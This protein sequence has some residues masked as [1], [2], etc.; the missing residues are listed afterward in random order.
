MQK[1]LIVKTL[2]ELEIIIDDE[3]KDKFI[4]VMFEAYEESVSGLRNKND[5]VFDKYNNFR[6]KVNEL[7]EEKKGLMEKMK[8]FEKIEDPQEAIDAIEKIK[9]GENQVDVDAAV[10]RRTKSLREEIEAVRTAK[11]K[12]LR[13]VLLQNDSLNQQM[14]Q[15]K[16]NFEVRDVA[17]KLGV[18]ER[19]VKHFAHSMSEVFHWDDDEKSFVGRKNGEPVFDPN[20]PAKPATFYTYGKMLEKEEPYLF[21]NNQNPGLGGNDGNTQTPD[22]YFKIS[23]GGKVTPTEDG[24]LLKGSNPK[25]Y[26]QLERQFNKSVDKDK[27]AA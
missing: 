16:F 22:K 10:E 20:D 18:E 2:D 24:W 5:E 1:D 26:E 13:D 12:E 25:E 23:A 14:I 6:D 15:Q 7:E 4:E 27:A 17:N 3:K 9:N 8:P 21:S 19:A 11:E